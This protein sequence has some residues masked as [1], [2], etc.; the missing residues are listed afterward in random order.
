MAR[1]LLV[2]DD[3]CFREILRSALAQ[4]GHDVYEAADGRQAV[5]RYD[6]DATD[7]VI[8][9]L[10]MPRQEGL[11]TIQQLR[12]RD[13]NVKIIAISGDGELLNIDL[14]KVARYFGAH[15]TLRKPF[16]LTDLTVVLD[17]LLCRGAAAAS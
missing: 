3:A 16:S 6:P 5:E 17:E 8:T 1:I 11:E 4:S 7:V 10:I 14:L 13:P 15:R 12:R 2:D 9:D